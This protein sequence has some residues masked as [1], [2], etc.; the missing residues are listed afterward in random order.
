MAADF[1]SGEE[2]PR[3]MS[4]CETSI[5][6]PIPQEKPE[7]TACGTFM[8]CRPSRIS[9]K[10]IMMTE[11]ANE[12]LAAPPIPWFFTAKAINGTVALA[13][14]PIK[15]GLRPSSAITGAV[16]IDVKTPRTGGNPI[17]EAIANP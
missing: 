5:M 9:Q 1:V 11:A 16:R 13:V 14:P 3:M 7:T 10:A 15:T 4:N 8:M 12:T 17:S 2:I 6:P